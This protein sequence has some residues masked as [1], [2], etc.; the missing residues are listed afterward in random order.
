[1]PVSTEVDVDV[2]LEAL[3]YLGAQHN[4]LLPRGLE[5]L[6][7][8]DYCVPTRRLRILGE[9]GALMRRIEDVGPIA[10]L[11]EVDIYHDGLIV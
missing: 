4:S 8:V 3:A 2:H 1:M 10:L 11:K 6:H 7:E 5:V 9:A